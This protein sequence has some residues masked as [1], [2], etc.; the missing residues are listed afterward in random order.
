MLSGMA[1]C[2]WIQDDPTNSLHQKLSTG[3][4]TD[5]SSTVGQN[6]I[7]GATAHQSLGL[8]EV[9][10]LGRLGWVPFTL[11]FYK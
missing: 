2:N 1:P 7:T 8:T 3:D 6:P 5:H 10:L 11:I 4:A 9:S